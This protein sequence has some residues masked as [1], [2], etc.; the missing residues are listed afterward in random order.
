MFAM[1]KTRYIRVPVLAGIVLFASSVY[2]QTHPDA[3]SS[4]ITIPPGAR[5]ACP[6]DT[7]PN[8]TD[9]AHQGAY[10][11]AEPGNCPWCG[12]NLMPLEKLSW[13]RALQAAGGSEVAYTC[14]D[15]QHVFSTTPGTCPRCGKKLEPFKV[16]YTC[17]DPK[18]AGVIADKP[19]KCPDCSQELTPYRGV[20]LSPEMAVNNVPPHP[21]IADNAAY[22][23][24]EHPLA[25][26]D[27]PGLC[28]ICGRPL[29]ASKPMR[30]PQ[31]APAGAK[32]LCPMHPDKTSQ[33]SG[34]CPICGMEMV[35]V[36]DMP[37]P[38]SAPAAI[39]AQVNFLMEHYLALQQRFASDNTKD[40]TLHA[41]GLVGASD[42]LLKLVAEPD[43]QLPKGFGEAVRALRD[44][45]LKLAG[46]S[47]DDDRITFV[48]IGGAMRQIVETV[49]PDKTRYPKLYI[50]HCPMTKGD[51][52]Q[53]TDDMANPFYG[54]KMLKCGELQETR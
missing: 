45:A 33:S 35:R 2:G 44:A 20:W 11:S 46:K 54:F 28:P 27:K 36:E 30:P 52:I 14:P 37:H 41:L 24:P 4:T 49:R 3:K 38:A 17:P 34:T 42:A 48:T 40:A 9:P 16:M 43:A 25:H 50:F 5:Y 39:E 23:C 1:K 29:V 15:H 13:T 21:E 32:Y 53:T 7:H 31:P 22:R 47:L 18:H 12:M 26:S 10:F 8:E 6:M 51:W 19:G